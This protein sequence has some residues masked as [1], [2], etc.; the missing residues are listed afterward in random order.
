M[1]ETTARNRRALERGDRT[2]AETVARGFYGRHVGG[3]SGKHDNVRTYWEDQ[4]TQLVLR[5]HIEQLVRARASTRQGL[6][7]LDL[8]CGAGQGFD[9]IT[10]I[11]P[12]G[13]NL[14]DDLRHL[15]PHDR[16]SSYLGLDVSD[17]M[18]E[19]GRDNYADQP[20][21]RFRKADLREGLGPVLSEPAFDVYFSSYGALS[22]LD[23][24][25]LRRLMADI[26]RHAQPG[27]VV[28]LDLL[29]RYSPEWPAYWTADGETLP[30]SM[31]YLYDDCE[32]HSGDFERFPLRFWTGAELHALCAE[33]SAEARI[34]IDVRELV[35]RSIFVGRHVD[36]GEYGS[37]LPPLRRLVNRLYEQD[38]RTRLAQFRVDLRPTAAPA[39]VKDFF[40]AFAASWNH[41]IDFTIARI[42]GGRVD[43]V[44]LPGWG[45]FPA[46]LQMAILTMD[47]VIE[48]VAWIDVGDVRA[49]VLEP[50]LAYVLRRLEV[51]MQRGLG[52]AHGLVAV[53][54][55]AG[56][57]G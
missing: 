39:Q 32:R 15:L 14:G 51:M 11:K 23:T 41:V 37:S 20:N 29:A 57:S 24:A 54:R 1:P 5:P 50:Q 9:L 34:P 17:A 45:D 40:S 22:H 12:E 36:T 42:E 7:I 19:Q 52:C 21:V 10:G 30:Y 2:Y 33:L 3:L 55:V 38:I 47:R 4:L 27:A 8:G 53:L 13:L 18:V 46:P 48:S 6:R 16:I 35:D 26:A 28:V 56:P 25:A 49:N 44:G 31:S 43:L